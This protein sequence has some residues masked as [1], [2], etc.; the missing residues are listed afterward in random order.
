MERWLPIP[1]FEGR[2]EVSD[3]GR[4]RTLQ[5][6]GRALNPPQHIRD[7]TAGKGYRV[8]QL[9]DGERFRPMYVHRAVLLA[10][11]GEPGCGMQGAHLDG[12][13]DNNRL[14]NLIWATV[15]E[16]HSHKRLHGTSLH[17]ERAP[18]HRLSEAQVQAARAEYRPGSRHASSHALAL[19]YGITQG[20][21]SDVLRGRRW[22]HLA[23]VTAT[24]E[25]GN[26][27]SQRGS[28][29]PKAK[30]SEQQVREA[31]AAWR[32]NTREAGS[33]ALARKYGITQSAMHA[34]LTGKRW[35]HVDSA[36]AA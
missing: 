27:L 2:Y 32:P 23:T 26:P 33:A 28:A 4:G 36:E 14:E 21:M 30:L 18:N 16:N 9:F 8:F 5:R 13:R 15:S 34:A 24:C 31:R 7:H 11:R 1:G 12:T 17:G 22:A 25:R 6:K 10:F 29:N 35:S 19:K 3:Q 20:H